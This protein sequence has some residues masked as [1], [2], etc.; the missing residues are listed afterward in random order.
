[1]DKPPKASKKQNANGNQKKHEPNQLKLSAS[2]AKK[3]A[4]AGRE[5]KEDKSNTRSAQVQSVK[6]TLEST[7]TQVESTDPL[8]MPSGV[9]RMQSSSDYGGDDFDDLPSPSALLNGNVSIETDDS[10]KEKENAREE[11]QF[12]KSVFDWDDWIEIDDPVEPLTPKQNETNTLQ[13]IDLTSQSPNTLVLSGE[14]MDSDNRVLCSFHDVEGYQPSKRTIPFVDENR[15]PLKR[16]KTNTQCES[17]PLY[18]GQGEIALV[19]RNGT[20]PGPRTD[21]PTS[22]PK[23]WEDIDPLLLDEFKDIVNFF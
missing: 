18:H 22:S 23:D 21:K 11:K 8:A 1:M 9:K 10:I 19:E 17:F 14:E 6:P 20:N 5:D 12:E 7:F 16:T 3:G 4:S 15:P 13:Q 2:M